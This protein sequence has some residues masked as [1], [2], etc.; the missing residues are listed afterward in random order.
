M[1]VL[2]YISAAVAVIG[3]LMMVTRKNAMHGLVNLIVTFLALACAFWTLGAPFA[4]VLQIVV[5]AG[6]ILV[7]FVFAVM[8]LNL[9]PEGQARRSAIDWMIPGILALILFAEIV[10]VLTGTIA[11]E[12]DITKTVVGAKAVGESLFTL[13]AIGIEVAS[14]LLLASLAAAYHYGA[15]TGRGAQDE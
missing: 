2:F 6:A 7:L 4:A 3:S 8:V 15:F 5:Y 14:V 1:S 11:P 10:I 9:Q 13:Y 12:V